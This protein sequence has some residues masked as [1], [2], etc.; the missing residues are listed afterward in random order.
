MKK[1]FG[2]YYLGLDLGTNSVGW[3]ATDTEYNLLKINS[4]ALWG[5]RLFEEAKTSE[6]MRLQRSS[7]RR[8]DR[9]TWRIKLLQ[10]LFSKAITAVDPA[11][12]LRIQ[13]S[14]LQMNE[15][16]PNNKV[17][18]SLFGTSFLSDREYYD[19]YP[20]IYHLR[21]AMLDNDKDAF[22]VRL[23]YIVLSHMFK[24][25][26]HFLFEGL[27]AEQV[28]DFN[29][30]YG[31]A[32]AYFCNNIEGFAD[33]D[34][35]DFNKA[36]E[37]LTNKSLSVSEK[38]KHL[39]VVFDSKDK[40]IKEFATFLS[41]GKGNF[42]A[43]FNDK[44][45]EEMPNKSFSLKDDSLDEKGAEIEKYL[46]DRYVAI[47]KIKAIVDWGVLQ[48]ILHGNKTISEG[49]VKIYEDHK[50]DL[51]LLKSFLRDHAKH[52]YKRVFSYKAGADKDNYSC[53]VGSCLLPSGK[54]AVI[55]R[56]QGIN[57]E[58]FCKFLEKTLK[59]LKEFDEVQD[60]T[61]Q[62]T[63]ID[64]LFYRIKNSTAFPKQVNK[65]NGV[66]PMQVNKTELVRILENA[67]KHLDFLKQADESGLTIVDK[68]IDIFSFRI[69]Y[70]V[71][72]LAGNE[73]SRIKKRC[74]CVRKEVGKIT[75]WNFETKIDLSQSA[76]N[77]IKNMTNKCSY[78]EG[79]DVLPKSSLLYSEFVTRNELN[80]LAVDGQKLP[81]E[82]INKL[83]EELLIKGRGKLNKKK[84]AYFLRN[85][86]LGYGVQKENIT[87]VDDILQAN[88]QSYKDLCNVFGRSFVDK[89]TEMMENIIKWITIFSEEKGMLLEKIKQNYPE[90]SSKQLTMLKRLRYKDWGRLSQTL[91]NSSDIAYID[92]ATGECIT[93]IEA[94]GR[95]PINF[96]QLLSNEHHYGFIR[97][98][99]AFNQELT[100]A[101]SDISYDYVDKMYI[102]PSVK[103]TIWQTLLIVKELKKI[104]GHD[105]ERIFL[106]MPRGEK[107]K[108]RTV[109]RK[110]KLQELYKR[111]KE[112]NLDFVESDI[113]QKM[114]GQLEQ[115]SEEDLRD[116]KLFY[117]FAQMGRCMYTGRRIDL[118][119]LY[120]KKGGKALYDKDH[121]YP[122]SKTK[123]DSLDNLVLVYYL[124]N[125]EK[126]DKYPISPEIQKK[127]KPFWEMLLHYGFISQKK[128]ERLTR[129][130]PLTNEELAGFINRQLVETSQATKAVAELLKLECSTSTLVYSRA[131]NVSDFRQE[132]DMLKCRSINDLHHAKDA[133]L[134]IVVGNVYHTKFAQNPYE[135]ITHMSSSEKY[136]LKTKEMYSRVVKRNDIIA[137]IPGEEGTLAKVRKTML[138]NN[139][140]YTRMP[141]ENK[142]KMFDAT[143][144]KKGVEGIPL[145]KNKP[146][147]RYGGYK[148]VDSAYF[149]LVQSEVKKGK[150]VSEILTIET[151][152]V[153]K[154][155]QIAESENAAIEYL[156]K[157]CG[158]FNPKIV[159]KK[160]L[161]NTLIELNGCRVHITGKSDVNI[162]SVL[163]SQLVLSYDWIKY[164]K[165]IESFD[166][167]KKNN[168]Q[169]VI[170]A[171]DGITA[172]KNMELYEVLLEK[173]K[174]NVY[175]N[176]PSKQ[177]NTLEFGRAYFSML[178]LEEQC[179]TLLEISSLF[180]NKPLTADLSS[181]GGGPKA[182]RMNFN[183]K[184]SGKKLKVVFQSVTGVFEKVQD[185]SL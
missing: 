129:V 151:V 80:N 83:I 138:K 40:Q 69:P 172:E 81:I 51:E 89:H 184:V 123:D 73:E 27:N 91:L 168:K 146:V 38:K 56:E 1:Q 65:G 103:R 185:Y 57:Q 124:E 47:E 159:I 14:N 79:E 31:E 130:T 16:Q 70:Y 121:I 115:Y 94:M 36:K 154:A 120:F 66:I 160:L 167:R 28:N 158:L 5:I 142:G 125:R 98:I 43:L 117:Y 110:Q 108:V 113:K 30:V 95:E 178:S 41:G 64:K 165:R 3:A 2:K 77:F 87:G 76:E 24:H 149:M 145:K 136:S 92:D 49:K 90:V 96:M 144:Y 55:H 164:F 139:V 111:T 122:R 62:I 63:E 181:I 101:P 174:A 67:S 182:G 48:E 161:K 143:M 17:K 12:Y 46:G 11:F 132:F 114:L 135:Y 15:K 166:K 147:D 26:G 134:N 127:M 61:E 71:G 6:E 19:R 53:Y 179:E 88:M 97:K 104:I 140:L 100:S 152:P 137:W 45:L 119:E 169:A 75:P 177:I 18:Y 171:W 35:G 155:K 37:I 175:C 44:D 131:G 106:E 170:T 183:K 33:W 84:I 58:S 21:K 82:V 157:E 39:T 85:N 50:R 102:A 109:S 23:L 52:L 173:H 141:V 180:L 156:V 20:T 153:Y 116:N 93:I 60:G 163:A 86:N 72:P 59:G 68:L 9:A 118:S 4:K 74:W 126:T 162:T 99:K 25:R 32:V 176:R 54:K 107:D 34:G 42:S 29:S 150:K 7:R 133:Y 13:E 78:L 8:I 105:P 148:G 128:F 22:D 10:E 112:I